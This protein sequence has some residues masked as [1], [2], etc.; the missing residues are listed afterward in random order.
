MNRA[1]L[2]R[3]QAETVAVIQ[4]CSFNLFASR[5]GTVIDCDLL[6]K[7]LQEN[8]GVSKVNKGNNIIIIIISTNCKDQTKWI[9]Y[10]KNQEPGQSLY[11][12]LQKGLLSLLF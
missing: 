10:K 4:N 11:H 6:C 5:L 9:K 7:L 12:G 3:N 1:M 2:R 8:L